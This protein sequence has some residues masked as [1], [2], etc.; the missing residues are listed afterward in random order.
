MA[1]PATPKGSTHNVSTPK[2]PQLSPA[3]AKPWEGPHSAAGNVATAKATHNT[4]GPKESVIS[5][6]QRAPWEGPHT[7]LAPTKQKLS[8]ST[9]LVAGGTVVTVIGYNLLGVTSVTVGGTAA[10]AVTVVNDREMHFTAPAKT[11]GTYDVAL[12]KAAGPD[13]TLTGAYTAA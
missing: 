6:D 3:Q 9:G 8:P 10:T 13:T 11:A 1:T 5:P 7:A 2:S 4:S 12:V